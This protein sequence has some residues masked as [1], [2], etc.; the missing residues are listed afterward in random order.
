MAERRTIKLTN[1]NIGSLTDIARK[2]VH[3]L[4]REKTKQSH[5]KNLIYFPKG[6]KEEEYFEFATR[7]FLKN[8]D[9]NKSVS[10]NYLFSILNDIVLHFSSINKNYVKPFYRHQISKLIHNLAK[11]TN[12]AKKNSQFYLA[13]PKYVLDCSVQDKYA[14]TTFTKQNKIYSNDEIHRIFTYASSHITRFLAA[15]NDVQPDAI[16]EF[17][18]LIMFLISTGKRPNEIINLSY[19]ATNDLIILNY[20]QIVSKSGVEI[21]DFQIPVGLAG[22]LERYVL[23]CKHFKAHSDY[24]FQ[25]SYN[26]LRE[27]YIK[28]YKLIFGKRPC[29]KLFHAFRNAFSKEASSE[30]FEIAQH[31][32]NHN[33]SFMTSKYITKQTKGENRAL[34][35][36]YIDTMFKK[37]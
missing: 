35:Q 7:Y 10:L 31:A 25:R 13:D 12:P 23:H 36:K 33:S 28:V 20:T 21:V 27:T 26:Q 15:S 30:N 2:P 16:H 11:I 9:K 8:K 14:E 24:L 22:I 34:T 37:R 17:C 29:G 1:L 3:Q 18:L 4:Q 32:L 5:L 19:K 6:G